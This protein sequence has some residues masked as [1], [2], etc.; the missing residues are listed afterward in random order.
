[1]GRV[2]E[3]RWTEDELMEKIEQL[4]AEKHELM[5]ILGHVGHF[6]GCIGYDREG[7]EQYREFKTE[8]EAQ[9]YIK[10]AQDMKDICLRNVEADALEIPYDPLEDYWVGVTDDE[11]IER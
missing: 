9:A 8:N 10:G 2:K 5:A 4:E 11:L 6:K 7:I 3:L 1:M